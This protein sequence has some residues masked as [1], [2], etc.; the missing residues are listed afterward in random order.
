[1]GK[2]L[3]LERPRERGLW[4]RSLPAGLGSACVLAVLLQIAFTDPVVSAAF[5][6]ADIHAQV[7]G[8]LGG[9]VT[10]RLAGPQNVEL[11]WLAVLV[12]LAGVLAGLLLVGEVVDFAR[13][14]GES[15][16]PVGRGR[17]SWRWRLRV[18]CG[19]L[20]IAATVAVLW[21]MVWLAA[22]IVPDSGLAV[23]FVSFTPWAVAAA[24]GAAFAACCAPTTD[25]RAIDVSGGAGPLGA[26]RSN[27][28][29]RCPLIA[30]I[31]LAICWSAVSFWLNERLYAGLWIPHGDSA[32]YEEHLWNIRHGKGFRSYLDQGLFLGEH[33]QFIHVFL[34]PLHVL[35]P[36]HLLLEL[37]ESLALGSCAIPMYRLARRAGSSDGAAVALAVAW[38]SSVPMHFLDIAIDFKTFR[39]ICLGLPFLLWAMDLAERRRLWPATVC[40]LLTLTAKEDFALVIAPLGLALAA[41]SAGCGETRDRRRMWWGGGVAVLSTAWLLLAVLVLIPWFR[42]GEVVHYSRYFG[43][44]GRSPGDLV[45]TAVTDPL[46][47]LRQL[48]SFRTAGYLVVFLVPLAG[49]PLLRPVRLAAALPSFVMLS[50]LQ[51]TETGR[52][53]AGFPPVPYHHFHAPLLPVLFW[54]AAGGLGSLRALRESG[55]GALPGGLAWPS[56]GLAAATVPAISLLA[57]V[58]ASMTPLGAGF[59]SEASGYGY[60]QRY[61]PGPRAMHFETLRPRLPQSARIASTDY[62][63]TRLTHCERSYDYSDYPRAVNDNQPGAPPD[64]DL[65]V[66]DTQHPWSRIRSVDEVP[67]LQQAPDDW[68]VWPDETDGYFIVLERIRG[69]GGSASAEAP[70][71]K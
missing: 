55:H 65:I 4:A 2:S 33:I 46:R 71:K 41:E 17:G 51:L 44:L 30:V 23:F 63:H 5:W 9:T 64:T 1:M 27:R 67:E 38:L 14:R 52:A 3:R 43:D 12:R 68:R 61:V 24:V 54:A 39:P 11:S 37:A 58:F 60:A 19:R 50:L 34:L 45:R 28:S 8:L 29:S 25:D 21:L 16:P 40:L 69:E 22:S 56:P 36:S 31:V 13:S 70:R 53:G 10:P 26:N 47:V 59:W 20:L 66:I 32:M 57:A 18:R 62:V 42:G 15:P 49:L 6:P 48:I 35:W 7:V